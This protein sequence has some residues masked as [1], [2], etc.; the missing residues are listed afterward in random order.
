MNKIRET[1][2]FTEDDMSYEAIKK[3]FYRFRIKNNIMVKLS[4]NNPKL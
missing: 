3:D 2:D 4:Q 1:F